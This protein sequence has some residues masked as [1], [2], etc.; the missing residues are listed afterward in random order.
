MQR[1]LFA[2]G[3]GFVSL[4]LFAVSASGISNSGMMPSAAFADALQVA[5][6]TSCAARCRSAQD[7]INDCNKFETGASDFHQ[8][9][10]IIIAQATKLKGQAQ[11][12][13]TRVPNL[14]PPMKMSAAEY[15]MGSKQYAA[16]LNDFKTHAVAY[17]GHLKQFQNTVGECHAHAQALDGVLKK[18]EIH[19]GE[20]HMNSSNIRP[21]HICGV[22][23]N[24]VNR[25]FTSMAN[26]MVTD[27]MRVLQ[28]ES[29]L[30]T[31]EVEL[32]N[33][34]QASSAG[35]IKAMDRAKREDGEQALAA[36]FGRLRE[37]YELLKSEKDRL[38][39]ASGHGT[40]GK[41]TQSSVS[42][43]INHH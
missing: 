23:Q 31:Q 5:S 20:F 37:E 38:A 7:I 12:L 36:E 2:L 22:L 16:D 42:G 19:V 41:I 11:V 33:A 21:P 4:L 13:Q 32:Q 3:A 43:K 24:T 29:Q 10:E 25:N 28:A 40:I 14:P 30:R 39:S 35:S 15:A 1:R 17:Q 27:Q 18:Y 26:Q 8:K 34:E 6:D 9:A